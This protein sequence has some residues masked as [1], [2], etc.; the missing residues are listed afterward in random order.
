MK[1][2]IVLVSGLALLLQALP[3]TAIATQQSKPKTF[4]Q[5]CQQIN[6]VPA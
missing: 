6:S 4:A 2:L 5:W 1:K 3:A